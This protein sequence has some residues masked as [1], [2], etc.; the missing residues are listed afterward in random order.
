MNLFWSYPKGKTK[1][2]PR[3]LRRYLSIQGLIL[4]IVFYAPLSIVPT[5]TDQITSTSLPHWSNLLEG[6]GSSRCKK[7]NILHLFQTYTLEHV[8]FICKKEN[9]FLYFCLPCTFISYGKMTSALKKL[10][11]RCYACLWCL[12]LWLWT[13]YFNPYLANV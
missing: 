13:V 9:V 12:W 4:S 6:T 5:L 1:T 2:R 7:P 11:N 10:L 8:S 3:F